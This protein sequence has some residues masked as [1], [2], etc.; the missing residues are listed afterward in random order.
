MCT[1][2]VQH[3]GDDTTGQNCHE[4]PVSR[5]VHCRAESGS[6][7]IPV[8]VQSASDSQRLALS[9][10]SRLRCPHFLG[11]LFSQSGR[12]PT[13]RIRSISRKIL[14][15]IHPCVRHIFPASL[16]ITY[17]RPR[18]GRPANSSPLFIR[19]SGE[20]SRRACDRPFDIHT[21]EGENHACDWVDILSIYCANTEDFPKVRAA[22]DPSSA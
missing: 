5:S 12:C 15:L 6:S 17:S 9:L 7:P 14:P 8:R 21:D 2:T 22:I 3:G 4:V 1:P 16:G 13:G 18:L 10:A 20:R 11:P 19:L